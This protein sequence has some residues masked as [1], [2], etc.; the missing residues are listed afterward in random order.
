MLPSV[1]LRLLNTYRWWNCWSAY[2]GLWL[3]VILYFSLLN[4]KQRLKNYSK[5]YGTLF[6]KISVIFLLF[7]KNF[8][9]NF[10]PRCWFGFQLKHKI[11]AEILKHRNQIRI[12]AVSPSIYC[13]VFF[14][15]KCALRQQRHQIVLVKA[16]TL[17][18]AIKIHN[19]HREK[20]SIPGQNRQHRR[21]L[22]AGVAS[23]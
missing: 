12:P 23:R 21:P 6:L 8:Y 14:P 7:T 19:Q 10:K 1:C 4:L 5:N 11:G 13:S 17:P 3:P 9:V 18:L 15:N 22:S 16:P 20:S 2:L